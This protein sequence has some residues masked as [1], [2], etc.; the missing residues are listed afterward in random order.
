MYSYIVPCIIG[1]VF[2]V[3]LLK[4]IDI[5]NEFTV[6]AKEGIKT[7]VSLLPILIC[8]F[9]SI[10]VFKA[11]GAMDLFV[12]LFK[13]LAK[14]INIPS[15]VSPLVLMRPISGSGSLVLFTQLI[16]KYKPDT[17]IGRLAAVMTSS[18]ETTLYTMSVY[19]SA[20]AIK[21]TGKAMIIALTCDIMS[22][23]FASIATNIVF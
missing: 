20:A 2:I 16:E 15:E 22:V 11:S 7:A 10:S 13:P 6:G 17:Y 18:N 12:Y 14:I 5:V 4:K 1:F 23:I 9:L 3:A 8:I 19:G 21:K